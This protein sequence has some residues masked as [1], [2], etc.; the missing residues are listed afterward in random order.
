MEG[1]IVPF[2]SGSCYHALMDFSRPVR[3]VIP[4][5]QGRIL[6]VMAESTGDLNLRTIA[7]LSG[8][9]VAHASRVLPWLA[10]L[11]IV[12]RREAPPSALFRFV[13]ENV[14]ARAI[15]ELSCA[16]SAALQELGEAA[17]VMSPTPVSVTVFGS[18]ARG[19]ADAESDLDV[20][21]VRSSEVAHDDPGWQ[22]AVERW[23]DGARRL[24]GNPVRVLEVDELKAGRLLRGRRPLW[25]D[26]QR[27]G[28]VIFGLSPADLKGRR[29]A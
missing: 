5:A 22:S 29:S 20:L 28:V 23:R 3:A 14:A 10:E 25:L 21:I 27:E 8:V 26:I 6:G 17:T 19:E 15:T 11:G 2:L 16:R 1:T 18:F 4:G 12:E 7:R 24:T 13:S 9:S